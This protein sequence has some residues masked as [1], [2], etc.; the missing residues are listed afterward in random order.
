M[1]INQKS[2]VA[3][4]QQIAEAFK[5]QI[6]SGELKSG[7]Y[8]PSVRSLA[9]DLKL[10]VVTTLKA[11]EQLTQEGLISSK[12]GKGYYVNEQDE[13]MIR[14]QHIR[15]VEENLQKALDAAKIANVSDEEV[16]IILKTLME[17]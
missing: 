12:A 15:I 3:L 8:L 11:Y 9:A 13:E 16:I 2:D 17:V 4:Y 1:Q 7:D 10:S 14:E 6:L 5:A